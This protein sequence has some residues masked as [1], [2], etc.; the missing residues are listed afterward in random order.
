MKEKG[1]YVSHLKK[2]KSYKMDGRGDR[3]ETVEREE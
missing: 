3:G 1:T 2:K